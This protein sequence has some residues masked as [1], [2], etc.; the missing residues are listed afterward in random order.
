MSRARAPKH[1]EENMPP[2]YE[3]EEFRREILEA[4]THLASVS[5]AAF[6]DADIVGT[7]VARVLGV[8]EQL[9]AGWIVGH[10]PRKKHR[11]V[12]DDQANSRCKYFRVLCISSMHCTISNH[13]LF[14]RLLCRPFSIADCMVK[15]H[16]CFETNPGDWRDV[17]SQSLELLSERDLERYCDKFP[18]EEDRQ[19]E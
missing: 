5:S 12:Y 13:H 1:K 6:P 17:N 4:G 7:G 8:V 11:G 2:N 16:V 10:R 3:I 14:V 19:E 18:N 15:S 9:W